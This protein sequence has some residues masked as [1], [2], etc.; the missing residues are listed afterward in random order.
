MTKAKQT[1]VLNGRTY[2]AA[3]GEIIHHTAPTSTKTVPSL[4]PVRVIS[5]IAPAVHT[6]TRASR[7]PAPKVAPKVQ[8]STTLKRSAVK[9]PHPTSRAQT[10]KV[11][12]RNIQ[13]SQRITRFAPHVAPAAPKHPV[14][15][16]LATQAAAMKKAHAHH[17]RQQALAKKPISSRVVKEHLLEKQLAKATPAPEKVEKA[18]KNTPLSRHSR[19]LSFGLAT[20]ALFVFGAYV[21]YSNL[22][23]L[24]VQVA[25]MNAGIDAALPKYQPNGFHITGPVAYSQG[26]VS[27]KY[28]ENGS[29]AFFNLTQRTSD[30]DPQAALDNYVVPES[31]NNYATHS[32]QGL[33]VYTYG[34]KA[35]WVNGGILHIIEGT[36]KLSSQQI[37]RIAT[38]M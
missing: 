31:N 35:V 11:V 1:I 34:K 32:A 36:A 30:W 14:D 9:P 4:R 18:P 33:T 7:H 26:E 28:L 15:H 16:E 3:T 13:R 23:N 17:V 21:T 27:V 29:N 38:S 22:P 10:A 25:S 37:E 8:K 2:D 20:L 5:D 24:S 19:T 6:V 12:H